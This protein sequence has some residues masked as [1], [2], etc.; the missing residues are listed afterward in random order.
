[1]G[2]L[3]QV[4][5]AIIASSFTVIGG[6]GA[7]LIARDF[8]ILRDFG[9]VTM[10]NVLFALITTLFVLPTLIVWIDSWRESRHLAMKVIKP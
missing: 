10:I 2:L 9:I 4:G 1:V 8:I 5:R 7:L 6:F 3:N